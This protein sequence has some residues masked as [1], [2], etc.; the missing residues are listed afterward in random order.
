MEIMHTMT[1]LAIAQR[2]KRRYYSP[3]LKTQMVAECQAAGSSVASYE[4][5]RSRVRDFGRRLLLTSPK[6][7][8]DADL[9]AQHQPV[10]RDPFSDRAQAGALPGVQVRGLLSR[11]ERHLFLVRGALD[12]RR[13]PSADASG[14]EPGLGRARAFPCL[15][16]C[17]SSHRRPHRPAAAILRALQWVAPAGQPVAE[18]VSTSSMT[19][20]ATG[21]LPG[22]RGFPCGRP[23]TPHSMKRLRQRV[24]VGCT[25][26]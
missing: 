9:V 22:L 16:P 14:L 8:L 10:L 17:R 5:M 26:R 6:G 11:I 13:V 18:S 4:S 2:P 23:A 24:S 7:L 12:Q 19:L 1:S 3:E 21:G 20:C 25:F 15:H